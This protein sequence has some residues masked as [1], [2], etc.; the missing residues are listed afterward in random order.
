M[1]AFTIIVFHDN[2][3]INKM[4]MFKMSMNGD[5]S[6]CDLVKQMQFGDDLQT[7][8]IMFDNVKCVQGQ[9]TFAYHVYDPIYWKVMMIAICD[10]QFENMEFNVS[11][12]ES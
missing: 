5:G 11:C 8:W 6:G 4:F 3:K 12:D 1:I 10:M 2:N 9:T 7:T